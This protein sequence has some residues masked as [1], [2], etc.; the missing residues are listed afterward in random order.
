M[1]PPLSDEHLLSSF[2]RGDHSA[3]AELARRYETRLLGLSQGLLGGRSDLA[4]DAV[5]DTWLRV[6]RSSETFDG[7]SSFKTWIYRITI[8]R[9][10]DMRAARRHLSTTDA[11][12][13][14]R[15]GPAMPDAAPPQTD[16]AEETQSLR[17]AVEELRDDRR[18]V[19]LLC[20]HSGMTHEQAADI[21]GLPLGTLKSRLHAALT[22]LRAAL[23]QEPAQ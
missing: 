20:Y 10:N 17:A 13:A 5:Q 22:Q 18:T 11:G 14:D 2:S 4:Q 9:C 15:A 21:L 3:L 16:H 6:I 12:D 19:V 23:A 8:N 1:D 7:R